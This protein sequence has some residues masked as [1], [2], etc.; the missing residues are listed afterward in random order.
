MR[1]FFK[2]YNWMMGLFGTIIGVIGIIQL[3]DDE[4][5][6]IKILII[7]VVF[8]LITLL[9]IIRTISI[10]RRNINLAGGFVGERSRMIQENKKYL[11][12]MYKN[13]EYNDVCNIGSVFSRVFYLAAA[14]Y[15]R[16]AI[17][18]MVFKSAE[19]LSRYKLCSSTLLDLGWTA[20]LVGMDKLNSFEYNGVVYNSPDDFFIQSIEYSKRI[21][22]NALISKGYR[23]LSGYYLTIGNYTEAKKYRNLSEDFLNEM[24]EGTDKRNLLANLYYCDAET[25]FMEKRY[26]DALSLCI[27][28][29]TLKQGADDETREIRYYAQHGK[30]VLM[31]NDLQQARRDFFDGLESAKKLK[32]IDEIS[33]NTY[34]QAICLVRSGQKHEAEVIIRRLQKEYGNVPLFVSDQFFMK[35][36]KRITTK[37]IISIEE[38]VSD[39]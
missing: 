6:I 8:S 27:S 11:A 13:S 20:L 5:L 19:T 21:N 17:G 32:R 24:P 3:F 2:N 35:E 34:G 1:D 31:Q 15:S 22:D 39:A 9:A 25:A 16:Y 18:I 30:I 7:F 10:N 36:Y 14:Y 26:G 4:S 23:H 12:L 37:H 38:D 29:D 28:A 33:K